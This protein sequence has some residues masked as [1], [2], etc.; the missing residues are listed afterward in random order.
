MAVSKKTTTVT[1]PAGKLSLV[2]PCYNEE[3]RVP[4][5]IRGLEE[6]TSKTILDYEIIIVDDGS[7]DGTV[8]TIQ[9]NDFIKAQEASGKLRIVRLSQNRGKGSA[10]KEGVAAATGT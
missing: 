6:F 5:M 10:L 1:K 3:S 2:V 4:Q 9:S 7:T 8:A